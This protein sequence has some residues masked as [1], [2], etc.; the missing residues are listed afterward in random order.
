MT[1]CIDS[2]RTFSQFEMDFRYSRACVLIIGEL[3]ITYSFF[4]KGYVSVWQTS[5]SIIMVYQNKPADKYLMCAVHSTFSFLT[6]RVF[7]LKEIS[8]CAFWMF[9]DQP[10]F[11]QWGSKCF[12][13]SRHLRKKACVLIKNTHQY[14]FSP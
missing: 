11:R 9:F 3:D 14:I 4:K 7:P 10:C 6:D 1:F 13:V 5:L 2:T 8:I 12:R